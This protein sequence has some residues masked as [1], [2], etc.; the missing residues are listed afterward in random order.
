[1]KRINNSPNTPEGSGAGFVSLTRD[2]IADLLAEISADLEKQSTPARRRAEARL[3]D[4]DLIEQVRYEL[5]AGDGHKNS[6]QSYYQLFDDLWLYAWPVLQAF[7]RTH[8]MSQ[9]IA[10]Y[11]RD[12]SVSI[13]PEDM[14]VLSHS[15]D[16]R[17]EL[18]IDVISKAVGEFE[19]SAVRGER[20]SPTG[21]ASLR[22]W[23]I[24]TCAL[25]FPHAY[26]TWSKKRSDRLVGIARQHEINFDDLGGR[27]VEG[28]GDPSGLAIL[29]R[30][31]KKLVDHA[32][33]DTKVILGLLMQEKTHAQIAAELGLTIRAVEG[34]I[35]R[36]RK[37]AKGND[38]RAN[39]GL[40]H[41]AL[42]EAQDPW[43]LGGAA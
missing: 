23:F 8:K 15:A 37:R 42:P 19:K 24:G 4:Y 43:A 34:R 13:R 7:I 26:R 40:R 28:L 14:W 9:V 20:W 2:P 22:T 10:R 32:Q 3:E 18:A 29:R 5:A 41:A 12:R 39:Q 6:R 27:M 16:E 36:W 35:Y 38:P 30:D 17:M 25:N 31:L 11:A 21:G 1:M 33:P